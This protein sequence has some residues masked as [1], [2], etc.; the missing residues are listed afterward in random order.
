MY[1]RYRVKAKRCTMAS[2]GTAGRAISFAKTQWRSGVG[3]SAAG[4]DEEAIVFATPP[5]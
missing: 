1:K 5:D 3:L 4:V 2:E